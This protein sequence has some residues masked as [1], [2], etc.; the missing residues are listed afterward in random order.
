MLSVIISSFFL[1]LILFFAFTA[2][3]RILFASLFFF[4]C[5]IL[6][7]AAGVTSMIVQL[8]RAVSQRPYRQVSSDVK[9]DFIE[10]SIHVWLADFGHDHT[11]LEKNAEKNVFV[12]SG[13]PSAI[14]RHE[15][16]AF[17]NSP[18][19]SGRFEPTLALRFSVDG[20]HLNT[21]LFENYSIMMIIVQ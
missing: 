5:E 15:N 19:K 17:S 8:C 6:R 16:G 14:I 20:K 13:L 10:Y 3:W 4:Y 18:F 12:R 21:E 9:C 1:L 2:S 11:T 7:K